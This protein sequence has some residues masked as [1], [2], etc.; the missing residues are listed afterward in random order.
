[1]ALNESPNVTAA[2]L[3]GMDSWYS[4]MMLKGAVD[5]EWP[6]FGFL[7]EKLTSKL[8]ADDPKGLWPPEGQAG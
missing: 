3:P 7:D 2:F 5:G 4:V 8:M 1:M 6:Q